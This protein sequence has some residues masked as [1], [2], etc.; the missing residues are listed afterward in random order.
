MGEPDLEGALGTV[1]DRLRE[2]LKLAG[3]AIHL[4]SESGEPLRITCGDEDA[5]GLL[6]VED[7]R[8]A[9]VLH[10]GPAPTQSQRGVAG[11]WVRLWRPH[12]ANS[13]GA[14]PMDNARVHAVPVRA[15]VRRVGTIYLVLAHGAAA[16]DPTDDR[17]LSALAGQIGLVVDRA[18]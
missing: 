15:G 10:T 13:N 2:E 17:L 5:V 12:P 8:P 18:R 7:P 6:R 14:A 3:V 11:H 1:A 4:T 16:F 9:H